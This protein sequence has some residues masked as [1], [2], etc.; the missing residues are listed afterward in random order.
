MGATRWRKRWPEL[1]ESE[2]ANCYYH[3]HTFFSRYWDE[4]DFIPRARRGGSAAYAVPYNGQDTHFH[5][6]TK[7]SHYVKSGELFSRFAYK[8]GNH[9]V[10]FVIQRADT[11]KTTP[12]APPSTSFRPHLASRSTMGFEL[13]WPG[14]PPPMQNKRVYKRQGRGHGS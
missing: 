11:E 9:E 10:R 12:K 7:G 6:A 5:W 8:D 1:A 2:A 14:A 4:G 13:A 3:L